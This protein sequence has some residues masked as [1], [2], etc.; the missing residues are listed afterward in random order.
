MKP[1][2]ARK[3]TYNKIL[4]LVKK[5]NFFVYSGRLSPNRCMVLCACKVR[6]I[7]ESLEEKTLSLSPIF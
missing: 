3:K 2:S 7:S 5:C 6:G 4:N 1:A